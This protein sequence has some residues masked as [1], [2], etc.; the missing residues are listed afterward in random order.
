MIKSHGD[1]SSIRSILK[2][3][4]AMTEEKQEEEEEI[5]ADQLINFVDSLDYD[6]RLEFQS[7]FNRFG[8]QVGLFVPKGLRICS[9]PSPFRRWTRPHVP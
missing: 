8:T 5:D 2:P 4:W 6:E 3:K 1:L 7:N 9:P